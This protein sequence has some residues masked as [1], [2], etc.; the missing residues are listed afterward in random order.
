MDTIEWLI[1][2]A[3]DTW[4]EG[5]DVFIQS[6]YGIGLMFVALFLFLNSRRGGL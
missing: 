3:I 6:P 2:D 5:F 1:D 4:N